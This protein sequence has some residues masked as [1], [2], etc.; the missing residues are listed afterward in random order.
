MIGRAPPDLLVMD[1]HMPGMDGFRMLREMHA[2][3][4]ISNTNIVVVTGLDA[5][6]IAERGGLPAGVEVLPKPIPFNRLLEIATG[7]VSQRRF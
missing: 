7:L 3:P 4:E 5:A 6:A 2:S 1:L